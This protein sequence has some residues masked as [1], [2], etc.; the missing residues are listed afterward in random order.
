MDVGGTLIILTDVTEVPVR[1][2][3][4]AMRG[5]GARRIAPIA[6]TG[7]EGEAAVHSERSGDNGNSEKT[8]HIHFHYCYRNS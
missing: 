4:C 2:R 5:T 6:L 3:E 8:L 1:V 7:S